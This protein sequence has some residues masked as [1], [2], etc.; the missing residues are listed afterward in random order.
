LLRGEDEDFAAYIRQT[1][2]RVAAG[3]RP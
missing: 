1:A 3:G 2:D